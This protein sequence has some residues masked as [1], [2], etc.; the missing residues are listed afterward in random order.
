MTVLVL[1]TDNPVPLEK[2]K[3]ILA[4]ILPFMNL[5]RKNVLGMI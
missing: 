1:T 3:K 5:S 4:P 2:L